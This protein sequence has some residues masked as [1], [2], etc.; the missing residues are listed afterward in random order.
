MFIYMY[1]YMESR[2]WLQGENFYTIKK[3]EN[4]KKF[5]DLG[6]LGAIMNRLSLSR[7]FFWC[8]VSDNDL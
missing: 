5:K 1:I 2:V 6:G 3:P 4:E 8:I 7:R